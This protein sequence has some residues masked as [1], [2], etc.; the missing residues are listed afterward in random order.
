MCGIAGIISARK[1]VTQSR[2]K[3]MTDSLRHRGPD[4]EGWW[5][6]DDATVGLGSRKRVEYH[7]HSDSREVCHGR[8]LKQ[9]SLE[10]S[11][12]ERDRCP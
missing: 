7:G 9:R 8:H 5:C 11:Q 6:S 10:R 4:A 3:S 12:S 1:Q 2:L